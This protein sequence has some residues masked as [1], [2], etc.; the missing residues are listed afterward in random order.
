MKR[1]FSILI[2][3]AAAG[4]VLFA[5][6]CM[7]P[8]DSLEGVYKLGMGTAVT[9]NA[10][11]GGKAGAAVTTVAVITDGKGTIVD[12]VIDCSAFD[13]AFEDV[14][15]QN[16]ME[17]PTKNELGDNYGMVAYAGATYEWYQQAENFAGYV[18]GMNAK[19]ATL[20]AIGA[21][22][23]AG[24]SDLLAGCT[25]DISDF[26]KALVKA[27]GDTL[28]VTFESDNAPVLSL[29]FINK[30]SFSEV[31]EEQLPAAM[32]TNIS[33]VAS[34]D[35]KVLAA[36]CDVAE[37]EFVYMA[38]GSYAKAHFDGT[39]REKLDSYGMVAFA[40]AAY[41]WYQQADHFCSQIEGLD[42]DGISSIEMGDRGQATDADIL[43]GCTI[44][45]GDFINTTVKALENVAD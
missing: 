12:C 5:A 10:L 11:D 21:D 27:M 45:V 34:L 23:K 24:D 2:A 26:K 19:D 44:A 37:T 38:D 40:G 6:A 33:A 17:Y 42:K 32:T 3:L 28:A 7:K 1:I 9:L 30:G 4:S 31:K 8:T 22:G 14:Q 15:A 39:K 16:S 35:G 20:L 41:E 43:A 13:L 18:K 36:V 29:A 25:I